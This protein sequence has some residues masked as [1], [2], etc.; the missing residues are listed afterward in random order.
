MNKYSAVFSDVV[1]CKEIRH[2]TEKKKK[3]HGCLSDYFLLY[4]CPPRP[5]SPAPL[6][7]P[8]AHTPS[9]PDILPHDLY[10]PLCAVLANR[11]YILDKAIAEVAIMANYKMARWFSAQHNHV[12]RVGGLVRCNADRVN[13]VHFK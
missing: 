4:N 3:D 6:A 7:P 2:L 9:S 11:F 1:I 5:A 12:L 13:V 10:N 8:V